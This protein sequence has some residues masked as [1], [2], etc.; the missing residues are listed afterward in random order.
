MTQRRLTVYG[1]GEPADAD[2]FGTGAVGNV[3]TRLAP[4]APGQP[5]D[6]GWRPGGG[7]ASLAQLTNVRWVDKNTTVPLADQTGTVGAPFATLVQAKAALLLTGGTIMLVPGDYETEG[8][9]TF[10]GVNPFAFI[11]VAGLQM[12]QPD[13]SPLVA[14]HLPTIN[15]TASKYVQGCS[16][17]SLISTSGHIEAVASEIHTQAQAFANLRLWNCTFTRDAGAGPL[18]TVGAGTMNL[19]SCLVRGNG[20][21]ASLPAGVHSM[22]NCTFGAGNGFIDGPAP[23]VLVQ[24]DAYTNQLY[25]DAYGPNFGANAN[26]SVVGLRE[27]RISNGAVVPVL[28]AGELGYLNLDVSLVGVPPIPIGTPVTVSCNNDLG[29]AG[30]GG[31]FIAFARTS[32]ADTVRLALV[33]ALA[34]GAELFICFFG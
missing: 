4:P 9:Q 21:M 30:V 13:L 26:S 8:T 7:G 14:C 22:T 5:D 12:V 33:G 15:G 19:N 16:C 25:N 18:I 29:V 32:A 3:L 27:L 24:F 10:D 28:A 31:G 6:Y 23:G 11:N 17:L 20:D 1:A 2:S 34:G